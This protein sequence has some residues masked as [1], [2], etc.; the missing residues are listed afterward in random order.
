MCTIAC[1]DDLDCP[2]GSACV[3]DQGGICA[4]L[5]AGT[6]CS[7]FGPGWRCTDRDRRGT[8]GKIDV[9]RGG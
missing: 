1:Q 3:D 6:D 9:C 4:V 7:A 5:C 2:A 8:D